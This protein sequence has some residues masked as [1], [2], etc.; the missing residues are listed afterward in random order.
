V[1]ILINDKVIEEL[2][3]VTLPFTSKTL[4]LTIE[5]TDT[6]GE[7]DVSSFVFQYAEQPASNDELYDALVEA[8][9]FVTGLPVDIVYCP[10]VKYADT[11]S[12]GKNAVALLGQFA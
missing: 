1:N 4:G 10:E 3:N 12:E 5:A 6:L 9:Q 8:T 7:N 2:R 11:F